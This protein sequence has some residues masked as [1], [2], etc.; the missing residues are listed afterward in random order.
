M[1]DE[2]QQLERRYM[3]AHEAFWLALTRKYG[4][5]DEQARATI[6]KVVEDR[7]NHPPTR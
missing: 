3:V 1:E 7:R 2:L 4:L 6:N 5:T